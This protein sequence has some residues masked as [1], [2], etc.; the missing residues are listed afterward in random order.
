MAVTRRRVQGRFSTRP[1]RATDWARAV[2]LNGVPGVIPVG[3]KVLL[4]SFVQLVPGISETI[5]RTRGEFL[6]TSDQVT[7][8]EQQTGAF[9]MCVVNDIALAAGAASIPGPIFDRSDDLWFVWE[10][11]NWA[12]RISAGATVD[13]T[14]GRLVTFDSKAMRKV[15][16][17][18]GI[19]VMVENES[20]T[21]GF[22]ITFSISI[23]SQ[24]R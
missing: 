19:A 8:V 17:G 16:D 24:R 13:G 1:R 15:E 4:T 18:Y 9:G 21:A 20:T 22:E 6:I 3:T 14:G 5:L 23:L 7:T 12:T 10:P 11:F 2:T